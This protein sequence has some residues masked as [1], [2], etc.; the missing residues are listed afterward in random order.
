MRSRSRYLLLLVGALGLGGLLYY[1]LVWRHRITIVDWYTSPVWSQPDF[2]V[3][4]N[5]LVDRPLPQPRP[6]ELFLVIRIHR[7]LHDDPVNLVDI[8]LLRPD[9]SSTP[10]VAMPEEQ[11][12]EDGRRILELGFIVLQAEVDAGGLKLKYL[13]ESPVEL[14]ALPQ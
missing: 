4:F 2:G 11:I 5:P 6:G 13:Y 8:R 1:T 7:R 9:G 3:P 12:D 14:P 10:A